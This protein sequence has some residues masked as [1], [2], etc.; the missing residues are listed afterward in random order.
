MKRDK[1]RLLI[2]F[3]FLA[4]LF[5]SSLILTAVE[6]GIGSW[7]E[8]LWYLVVTLTTVGYGDLVPETLPGRLIGALFLIGSVGLLSWIISLAVSLL[9][10]NFIPL[11]RL[12]RLG[13][14]NWYLF[15][16]NNAPGLSLYI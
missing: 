15:S 14:K 7:Q 4:V 2:L 13:R 3:A 1:K 9:N 5:L 12:R 8:G 11:M 10:G 16:G 6:D